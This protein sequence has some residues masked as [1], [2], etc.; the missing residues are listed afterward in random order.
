VRVDCAPVNDF[1]YVGSARG[2][3][4]IAGRAEDGAFAV[5]GRVELRYRLTGHHESSKAVELD[6]TLDADGRIVS[7]RVVSGADDLEGVFLVLAAGVDS[8]L[9]GPGG[10]PSYQTRCAASTVALPRGA[11]LRPDGSVSLNGD[12]S[13]TMRVQIGVVNIGNE[14]ASGASGR[15]TIGTTTASAT[16]HPRPGG[17]S[18]AP[19]AVQPGEHGYVEVT[20]PESTFADCRQPQVVIDVD[21]TFQSG[22]PDPFANDTATLTVPCVTFA[23]R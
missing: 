2:D 4:A 21:H 5:Q 9:D 13:G 23:T 17:T 6:G 3:L 22:D 20:V 7:A 15:A 19:N 16:L 8:H 10:S 14:P 11:D 1:G 12:G 18:R